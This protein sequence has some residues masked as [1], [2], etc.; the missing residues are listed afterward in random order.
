MRQEVFAEGDLRQLAFELMRAVSYLH[1]SGINILNIQPSH[2]YITE[3]V[4]YIQGQVKLGHFG[5]SWLCGLTSL[6]R[7][8]RY[9]P[10]EEYLQEVNSLFKVKSI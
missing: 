9:I 5:E 3:Q 4:T 7:E 2:I 1:T 6:N 10:P 8:E